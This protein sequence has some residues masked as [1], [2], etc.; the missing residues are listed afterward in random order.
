MTS[1]KQLFD[2]AESA[3]REVRHGRMQIML[4]CRGRK[5][6]GWNTKDGHWYISKVISRDHE[7]LMVRHGF[8][9]MT[10]SGGHCWWQL[11]GADNDVAFK[12]IVQACPSV[13]R[14]P[15]LPVV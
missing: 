1:V 11:D 5:I 9:W 8:R 15:D 12:A 2:A 14:R 7:D 6:G 10:K 4:R 3:G 13:D